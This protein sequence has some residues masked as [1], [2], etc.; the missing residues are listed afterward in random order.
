MVGY[1]RHEQQLR[2]VLV[3]VMEVK[4]VI[5]KLESVHVKGTSFPVIVINA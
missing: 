4:D 3:D 5:L 1:G 2:P